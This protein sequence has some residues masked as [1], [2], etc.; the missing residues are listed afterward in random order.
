MRKLRITL[1]LVC[2]L[3][4]VY[5]RH[6]IYFKTY[7]RDNMLW[8][9]A[10]IVSVAF[11]VVIA[12]TWFAHA[13]FGIEFFALILWL[14][15]CLSIRISRPICLILNGL[16]GVFLIFA[17]LSCRVNYKEYVH[18]MTQ[19]K[20][21]NNT[22]IWV[23]KIT[24]SP[25]FQRFIVPCPAGLWWKGSAEWISE[26]Y[27]TTSFSYYPEILRDYVMGR[28]GDNTQ[29]Y[30]NKDLLYYVKRIPKGQKINEV[31]FVLRKAK[32]EEIPFY[33]RPIAHRLARYTAL[34]ISTHNYKVVDIYG[35]SYLLVDKN[36]M[37]DN[38]V[39]DI[40]YK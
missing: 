7:V 33:M 22:V 15:L 37:V 24:I 38:R 28:V 34:E 9:V 36:E 1:I 31:T 23:N 25:L 19:I 30:T 3:F 2:A 8:I 16:V 39:I 29:F 21:Q 26:R 17:V 32:A 13:M 14:K 12:K 20:V 27:H 4:F 11:L 6:K 18:Q 10:M 40:R 35:Q 5:N